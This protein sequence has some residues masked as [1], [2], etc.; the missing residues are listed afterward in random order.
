MTDDPYLNWLPR[1]I[2]LLTVDDLFTRI[3]QLVLFFGGVLAFVAVVYS[4]Y[5]MIASGGDPTKFAAGRVN[6]IRAVIGII[7]VVMAYFIVLF[8]NDLARVT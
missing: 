4:G 7:V 2:P 3:V 1:S 6:L 8:A 5:L